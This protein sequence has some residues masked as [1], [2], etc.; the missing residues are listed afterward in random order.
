MFSLSR[1][2][3]MWSNPLDGFRFPLKKKNPP[4]V[5]EMVLLGLHTDL[6]TVNLVIR[7]VRRI[8]VGRHISRTD[9]ARIT[10]V[11]RRFH[12]FGVADGRRPEFAVAII[13]FLGEILMVIR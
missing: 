1:L 10:G 12:H 7:I 13:Q 3:Q 11:G 4:I 8:G 2:R 9:D 5:C 6:W